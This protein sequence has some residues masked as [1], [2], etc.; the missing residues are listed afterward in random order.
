MSQLGVVFIVLG[1]V[2]TVGI[3]FLLFG[4]VLALRAIFRALFGRSLPPKQHIA[5]PRSSREYVRR[6]H[7]FVS[8]RHAGCQ[9]ENPE[10]AVFC[11]TCGRRILQKCS[12]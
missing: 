10:G 8:C 1:L 3:P 2:V 11:R 5:F 9:A 6:A 12:A 7:V 4:V